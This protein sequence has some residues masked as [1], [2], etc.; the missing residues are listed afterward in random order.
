MRWV[1]AVLLITATTIGTPAAAGTRP[2]SPI[3]MSLQLE[4]LKYKV[5]APICGYLVV[6]ND[7]VGPVGVFGPVL[8]EGGGASL[9]IRTPIGTTLNCDVDFDVLFAF[10]AGCVIPAGGSAWWPIFIVRISG[11]DLALGFPGEYV[12]YGK[13]NITYAEGATNAGLLDR[14]SATLTTPEL[15]L[16]VHAAEPGLAEY[17]RFLDK[18]RF[19]WGIVSLPYAPIVEPQD[20]DGTFSSYAGEVRQVLAHHV[21]DIY[22]KLW[23]QSKGRSV[24]SAAKLEDRIGE[25]R[26]AIIRGA[27]HARQ[28][29]SGIGLWIHAAQIYEST[30]GERLDVGADQ[31]AREFWASRPLMFF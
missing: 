3:S 27:G 4:T 5:G 26:A 17:R 14:R 11:G 9:R 13:A 20:L 10:E 12:V 28:A 2:K 8:P 29:R 15:V 18:N 23:L 19:F 7:G 21:G 25:I 31:A 16:K 6:S 22:A 1:C 24:G 30:T